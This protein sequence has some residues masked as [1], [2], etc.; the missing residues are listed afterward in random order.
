MTNVSLIQVTLL[1]TCEFILVI[2]EINPIIVKCGDRLFSRVDNFKNHTRIHT[3]DKSYQCKVCDKCLTDLSNLKRHMRIHTG[4]KP[5]NCNVCSRCFTQLIIL[6]DTCASIKVITKQ[7]IN[8]TQT[9]EN[10]TSVVY[11][12]E[13][14]HPVS[15]QIVLITLQNRPHA[16][17]IIV[18]LRQGNTKWDTKTAFQHMRTILGTGVFQ[19]KIYLG[20]QCINNWSV[21]TYIIS[22]KVASVLL[23]D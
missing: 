10:D 22:I 12:E 16:H 21:C 3:G 9:E 4:D 1:D 18:F 5:Y 20:K 17:N 23:V 6:L 14:C 13:L 15:L 7:N 19:S 2:Q 8:H 11:S